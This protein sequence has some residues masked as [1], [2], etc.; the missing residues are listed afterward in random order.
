MVKNPPV[1]AGDTRDTDLI[2][3]SEKLPRA[4]RGNIL[5][6]FCLENPI[7]RGALQVTV[8]RVGKSQIRLSM[9][10]SQTVDMSLQQS[11]VS[12]FQKPKETLGMMRVC[13]LIWSH[14]LSLS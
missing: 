1:N 14:L 5:Q 9:H 7:D 13:C 3:G 8:H 2:P 10:A 11:Q 12:N 6:F 4:G